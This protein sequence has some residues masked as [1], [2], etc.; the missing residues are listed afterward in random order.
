MSRTYNTKY[1]LLKKFSNYEFPYGYIQRYGTII[2]PGEILGCDPSRTT[3]NETVEAYNTT[4]RHP[5]KRKKTRTLGREFSKT[6]ITGTRYWRNRFGE[7]DSKSSRC[8]LLK[9]ELTQK[10]RNRLKNQAKEM[11]IIALND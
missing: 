4:V 9:R 6:G 11:I 10:R 5:N 3:A 2:T 8:R 7:E 1:D